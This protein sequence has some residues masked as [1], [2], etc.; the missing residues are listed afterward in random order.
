VQRIIS[1]TTTSTQTSTLAI[2]NAISKRLD[3]LVTEVE[4]LRKECRNIKERRC[5][6]CGKPSHVAAQCRQLRK[7]PVW[8]RREARDKNSNDAQRR[9]DKNR[10][11]GRWNDRYS[12]YTNTTEKSCESKQGRVGALSVASV[13][14]KSSRH[15]TP[16]VRRGHFQQHTSHSNL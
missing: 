13:G 14:L 3:Q 16:H 9:R 6:N 5:W 7:K 1:Q 8:T 4:E 10:N 12:R 11:T 2:D 15:Y